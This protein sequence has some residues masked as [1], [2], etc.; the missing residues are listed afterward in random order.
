MA[1]DPD[2]DSF[3]LVTYSIPPTLDPF[4]I[5]PGTGETLVIIILG[6]GWTVLCLG[7]LLA[8]LSPQL[9]AVPYKSLISLSSL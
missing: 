1:N 6:E 5:Q 9:V 3:G 8:A 2:A 7:Q 4:F